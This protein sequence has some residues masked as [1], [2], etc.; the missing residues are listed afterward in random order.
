MRWILLLL[1][2][3]ATALG[4]APRVITSIAPLNETAA[5]IMHGV[6]E[7]VALIDAAESPHHFA[8]KPSQLRL[9]ESADLVIWIDRHF[10]SGFAGLAEVLPARVRRLELLPA[11]GGDDGHFWFSPRR[12]R[13]AAALIR[14]A[15]ARVD[16]GNAEIYAANAARLVDDIGH[17][18]D[19]L[20]RALR[21]QPLAVL[22]DHEFL[23]GLAAEFGGLEVAAVH[24]SH[25]AHGGIR[26][27]REIEDWLRR[28][29]VRC[30]LTQHA[31]SAAVARRLAREHGLEIID[32]GT[33]GRGEPPGIVAR[34]D[35]LRAALARCAA[36]A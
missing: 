30:L 24:D 13:A 16:P 25:D 9:L 15:L 5:A 34:V 27:L 14:D 26:H 6:G 23:S 11:L 22:T 1:G 31:G 35:R 29:Q 18:G 8:L 3:H 10:E 33:P 4:A 12:L 20:A 17:R 36:P 32:I 2:L 28:K 7:P 19:E 21:R